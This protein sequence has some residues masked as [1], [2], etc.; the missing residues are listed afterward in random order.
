MKLPAANCR[1]FWPRGIKYLSISS[2]RA[3]RKI[4]NPV[5]TAVSV[6]E[7][8]SI[9]RPGFAISVIVLPISLS[10]ERLPF[11]VSVHIL[12]TDRKLL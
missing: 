6:R 11:A 4:S 10:S 3:Q 7:K 5:N 12:K 1:I 9:Q 2:Q 8:L